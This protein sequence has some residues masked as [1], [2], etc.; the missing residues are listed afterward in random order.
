[1]AMNL[2]LVYRPRLQRYWS[3]ARHDSM[4][5]YYYPGR[6]VIPGAL[7]LGEHHRFFG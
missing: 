3:S 6:G 2:A 1:M 5:G 4:V 7:A